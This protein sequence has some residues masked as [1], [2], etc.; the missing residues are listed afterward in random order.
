MGTKKLKTAVLGLKEQG[1]QLLE[2]AWQ[3]ESF[4]IK[5][6]ADTNGELAEKTAA[7]YDSAAFDDCR[8]LII[9]NQLDVL[10]VAAPAHICNEY[11][12][13]AMEKGAG[14]LK[15]IPPAIDFEQTAELIRTAKKQ[16]TTFAVA[17]PGRF[18]PGFCALRN[19]L[20]SENTMDFHLITAV[21]NLPKKPDESHD[22]WLNDPQ[23]A[24]GGVL[25]HNCY[26]IIDEI[27]FNFGVPQQVYSL[28]I[29]HAPDKRQRLSI[30][31]DTAIVTMKFSDV[32]LGNL[33]ASRT[34]GPPRQMLKLHSMDKF[35]TASADSFTVH[36]NLGNII[37]QSVYD[38]AP[39]ESTAKMLEDFAM[40][41]ISPDKKKPIADI[42]SDLNNMAVIEAAYL[43]GR[44][45]MPEEPL[46]ILDMAK[47]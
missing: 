31:E 12:R 2:A 43:S 26:E 40:S 35:L 36:D 27:T 24:G 15:L 11:M 25:L 39:A 32:L 45:A 16:N 44:T 38:A 9:Q 41:L 37:E 7:K 14:V 19:Y 47:I 42:G 23:L 29:N 18:W 22:R 30:T 6:V 1:L 13:S 33:V 5:A 10:I 21:C 17:N 8:Q 4:D 46:R 28:N 34:F 3:S 20:A